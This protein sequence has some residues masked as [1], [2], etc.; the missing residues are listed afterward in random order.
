MLPGVVVGGSNGGLEKPCPGPWLCCCP[1]PRC[2]VRL[3][4]LWGPVWMTAGAAP[5]C[6]WNVVPVPRCGEQMLPC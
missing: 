3:G 1:R 6:V 2:L 4:L 5:A